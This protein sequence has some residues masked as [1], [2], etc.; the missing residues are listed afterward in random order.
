MISYAYAQAASEASRPAGSQIVKNVVE[1]VAEEAA[2]T[3][4]SSASLSLIERMRARRRKELEQ[5]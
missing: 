4:Q 3:D 1:N 5:Q 2:A